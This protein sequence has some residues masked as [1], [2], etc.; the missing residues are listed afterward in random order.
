MQL[1]LSLSSSLV[2]PESLTEKDRSELRIYR[3]PLVPF[4]Q[5]VDPRFSSLRARAFS[6][7][8]DSQRVLDRQESSL[9]LYVSRANIQVL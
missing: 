9:I 1:R 2:S 5:R 4:L 3:F 6:A 7:I 8:L